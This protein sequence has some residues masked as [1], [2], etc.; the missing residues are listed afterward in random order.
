MRVPRIRWMPRSAAAVTFWRVSP[1]RLARLASS[2]P[3]RLAHSAST[4]LRSGA[5]PG[6]RSTTSQDR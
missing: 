6:S 3:L 2:T 4:G 5:Y 1:A